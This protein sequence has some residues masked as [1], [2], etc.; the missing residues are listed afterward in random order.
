MVRCLGYIGG[1][2][3]PIEQAFSMKTPEEAGAFLR[4]EEQKRL[5]EIRSIVITSINN[6]PIKIDD[7]VVGGPLPYKDAKSD[8]GVVVGWQTRL[9]AVSQD[10]ALNK[11]GTE[12]RRQDEKIQGVV[13]MRKGEESLRTIEGVKAKVNQLNPV[14]RI[15]DATLESLK[16]SGMPPAV[17]E[18]LGALNDKEIQ[19]PGCSLENARQAPC[20]RI[21]IA[22]RRRETVVEPGEGSRTG[23]CPASRWKPITTARSWSISPRK[24]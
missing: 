21:D 23:C 2:K 15:T 1:G 18:K 11:E 9:G 12:W 3:D 20:R 6:N 17:S 5:R 16:N 13:L 24:P 7:V 8:V 4:E 14:Y 19:H 22:W 10:K